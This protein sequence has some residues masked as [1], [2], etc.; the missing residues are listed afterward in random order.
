MTRTGWI[1]LIGAAA[2]GA[3]AVGYA[4]A[5]ALRRRASAAGPGSVAERQVAG[6]MTMDAGIVPVDPDPMTRIAGEGADADPPH[7]PDAHRSRLP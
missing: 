3:A 5:R 4:R 2:L 6:V 7:D 1:V